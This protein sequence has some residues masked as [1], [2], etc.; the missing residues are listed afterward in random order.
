MSDIFKTMY[1]EL[2]KQKLRKTQNNATG[3][4]ET[5]TMSDGP[6][7][8]VVW[9]IERQSIHIDTANTGCEAWLLIG[10]APG[11]GVDWTTVM[12]YTNAAED[13]ISDQQHPP[14]VQPGESIKIRIAGIA[15][16]DDISVGMQ[17]SVC[18]PVPVT[19]PDRIDLT[20]AEEILTLEGAS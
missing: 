1:V 8:G 3:T 11:G 2:Y 17:I 6:P 14:L 18:I 9:F 20:E 10:D 15:V 5:V 12:D 4:T 16:N 7:Q 19:V 13:D